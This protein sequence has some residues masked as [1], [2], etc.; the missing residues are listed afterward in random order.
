MSTRESVTAAQYAAM[1]EKARLNRDENATPEQIEANDVML[2][3]M[4]SVLT[5]ISAKETEGKTRR[6]LSEDETV[7]LLRSLVK[8]RRATAEEF[9]NVG[10]EDRA[11]R[12]NA[13][14]DAIEKHL[15]A[16]LDEDGHRALV[17]QVIQETGAEGPRGIGLV[18]KALKG[19]EGV[20]AALASKIAREALA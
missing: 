18:M 7:A 5:S 12:E 19:K 3:T 15:P 17:T 2:Q 11:V 16:L 13:E 14:A 9:K 4:R 1:H 20:D 8:R 6:D 10:A